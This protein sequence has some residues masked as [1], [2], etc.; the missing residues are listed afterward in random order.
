[1]DPQ[2][3]TVY[4]R[5]VPVLAKTSRVS[6]QPESQRSI[7]IQLD[8]QTQPQHQ[9]EISDQIGAQDIVRTCPPPKRPQARSK[10]VQ[11]PRPSRA[12]S[13]SQNS[14]QPQ[15]SHRVQ[16]QAK[17]RRDPEAGPSAKKNCSGGLEPMVAPSTKPW[18]V[19]TIGSSTLAQEPK[20]TP[21]ADRWETKLS[22]W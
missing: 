21:E 7:Q 17:R 5:F 16:Q 20:A 22:F 9:M 18:P 1:M 10:S 12:C 2:P 3:R 6:P 15:S 8:Q 4:A 11:P 14:S 13:G 19:F